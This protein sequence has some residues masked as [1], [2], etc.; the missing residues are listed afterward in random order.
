MKFD[1]IPESKTPLLT[2]ETVILLR[3]LPR[4]R[5]L[6]ILLIILTRNLIPEQ[7]DNYR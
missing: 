4:A 3:L 6:P 2:S 1:G 5:L 7:S